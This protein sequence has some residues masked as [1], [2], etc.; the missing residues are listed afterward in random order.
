MEKNLELEKYYI[1]AIDN[2][3]QNKNGISRQEYNYVYKL[4]YSKKYNGLGNFARALEMSINKKMS[5]HVNVP[6]LFNSD[7]F[8][9]NE[10]QKIINYWTSASFANAANAKKVKDIK[11]KTPF[12]NIVNRTYNDASAVFAS[13]QYVDDNGVTYNGSDIF[14]QAKN[15]IETKDLLSEH[16]LAVAAKIGISIAVWLGLDALSPTIAKKVPGICS[17]VRNCAEKYPTAT[18][19]ANYTISPFDLDE[20]IKQDK[21][22]NGEIVEG[23]EDDQSDYQEEDENYDDYDIVIDDGSVYNDV[24]DEV[25]F[26]SESYGGEKVYNGTFTDDNGNVYKYTFED[27]DK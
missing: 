12:L 10:K 11:E 24:E 16:P 25:V 2:I 13:K 8:S 15:E 23:E 20:F 5:K 4:V 17:L 18:K 9:E 7:A 1:N 27:R 6:E 14:V 3:L 22:N 21:I 19:I 26:D